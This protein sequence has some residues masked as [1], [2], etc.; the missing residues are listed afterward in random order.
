MQIFD[1]VRHR[2]RNRFD[3][4][5]E[6][7]MVAREAIV[8]QNARADADAMKMTFDVSFLDIQEYMQPRINSAIQAELDRMAELLAIQYLSDTPE[9]EQLQKDMKS[10]FDRYPAIPQVDI[11]QAISKAVVD[12]FMKTS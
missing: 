11:R 1:K 2:T 3:Q 9:G 4:Y 10:T 5:A 7:F 8:N 6:I 12:L